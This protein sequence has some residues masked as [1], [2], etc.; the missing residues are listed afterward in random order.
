[1]MNGWTPAAW[2]ESGITITVVILLVAAVVLLV[3]VRWVGSGRTSRTVVHHH[4]GNSA[5]A[6][7]SIERELAE[8]DDVLPGVQQ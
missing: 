2:D 4:A 8:T 3:A 5:L 6:P 1:M 7:G